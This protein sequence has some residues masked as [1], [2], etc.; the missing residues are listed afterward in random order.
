MSM[1]DQ[2]PGPVLSSG[3]LPDQHFVMVRAPS[4][5]YAGYVGAQA[6]VTDVANGSVYVLF[7]SGI[8]DCFPPRQFHALFRP[9]PPGRC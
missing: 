6:V 3:P 5:A 9:R 7:E 2:A 1:L 4:T 8:R